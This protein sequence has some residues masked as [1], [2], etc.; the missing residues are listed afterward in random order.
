M[1]FSDI[2]K[3]VT[4]VRG[5]HPNNQAVA[6]L[7]IKVAMDDKWYPGKIS[8]DAKK[9]GPKHKFTRSKQLQVAKK[10]MTLKGNG[11][12]VSVGA[13]LARA[14]KVATNLQTGQLY[15][16]PTT[17]KVFQAHCFDDDQTDPWLFLG[18]CHKAALPPWIIE[19][20]KIWAEKVK[21]MGHTPA[22]FYKNCV[23][24]DPCN[25]VIPAAKR[26]VFD[27]GQ[28]DKGRVSR[29]RW[30]CEPS[31]PEICHDQLKS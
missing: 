13:V 2:A 8:A 10:A 23:W 22:W 19:A 28:S 26:T 7:A 6:E 15:T 11:A 31:P 27:H 3:H 1:L 21:A 14:P 18:P 12:E 5:E 25:I 30:L 24:F 17:S 9:R 29:A 20:R 4:K 16:E